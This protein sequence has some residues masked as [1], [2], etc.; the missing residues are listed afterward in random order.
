MKPNEDYVCDGKTYT[1][2][3]VKLTSPFSLGYFISEEIFNMNGNSHFKDIES[4]EEKEKVATFFCDKLK[5]TEVIKDYHLQSLTI[6]YVDD[7]EFEELREDVMPDKTIYLVDGV[8]LNYNR[9]RSEDLVIEM[10]LD[11]NAIIILK[12]GIRK[13][14]YSLSKNKNNKFVPNCD[15]LYFL[16]K[17]IFENF[18]NDIT[19]DD[20]NENGKYIEN[21][22]YVT[23]FYIINDIDEDFSGFPYKVMKF[24][25]CKPIYENE[26]MFYKRIHEI[27]C[28]TFDS[29]FQALSLQKQIDT[30]ED[31][32]NTLK[33]HINRLLMMEAKLLIQD[34]QNS[35]IKS[36]ERRN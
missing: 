21:L 16:G 4:S 22:V 20:I 12:D 10:G 8:D 28:I 19:N 27:C 2:E 33:E 30:V 31:L 35:F 32:I 13:S 14:F 9:L 7:E 34:N 15:W 3:E 18:F 17:F 25:S 23:A 26:V 1:R 36:D 6:R 24:L 11:W 5:N 29:D